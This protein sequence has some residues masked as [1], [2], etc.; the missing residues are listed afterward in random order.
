MTSDGEKWFT[1]SSK[2]QSSKQVS[3][4]LQSRN[5]SD[6][7]TRK[8]IFMEKFMLFCD[9]KELLNATHMTRQDF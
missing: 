2:R 4:F 9:D 5:I 1:K 7:V 3:A 8:R 6:A